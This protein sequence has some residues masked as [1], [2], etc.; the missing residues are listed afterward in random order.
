MNHFHHTY[1]L[2]SSILLSIIL[3][4]PWLWYYSRCCR[5][6]D[7]D[8]DAQKK[9][10]KMIEYDIEFKLIPP[11]SNIGI[12]IDD[13]L[14]VLRNIVSDIDHEK[15]QVLKYQYCKIELSEKIA[16]ILNINPSH[17]SITYIDTHCQYSTNE[18]VFWVHIIHKLYDI[19]DNINIKTLYQDR[20][21]YLSEIIK[22]IFHISL[23]WNILCSI[24]P[25]KPSSSSSPSSSKKI[26]EISSDGDGDRLSTVA[27]HNLH[28]TDIDG[29]I[30][31]S[32]DIDNKNMGIILK[33]PPPQ[34]QQ[35]I[36]HEINSNVYDR[37]YPL[38]D[39]IMDFAPHDI[40]T[41]IID[42]EDEEKIH[43][44]LPQKHIPINY[45]TS[46]DSIGVTSEGPEGLKVIKG[47]K[48]S[49]SEGP[50]NLQNVKKQKQQ[51]HSDRIPFKIEENEEEEAIIHDDD[52]DD[53]EFN[54]NQTISLPNSSILKLDNNFSTTSSIFGV[55]P[56]NDDNDNKTVTTMGGVTISKINTTTSKDLE[57][58]TTNDH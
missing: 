58:N 35:H 32:N 7:D 44:E 53:D 41:D 13:G 51:Q 3:C 48:K 22:R 39:N 54:I 28:D 5:N 49:F 9:D 21:N 29:D 24:I 55:G 2:S 20:Y 27:I 12:S 46:T 37:V 8:D 19:D 30:S 25:Q 6:N 56:G 45:M 50:K 17:L 36:K 42:D 57:S 31:S 18:Y 38:G 34:Q 10:L 26:D 52:D 14:N 47:V 16:E 15:K 43:I 33:Y 4:L 11:P 40:I 1:L 23:D